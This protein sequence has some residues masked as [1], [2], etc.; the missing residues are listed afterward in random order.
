MGRNFFSFIKNLFK[1]LR[2]KEDKEKISNK[3]N[4]TCTCSVFEFFLDAEHIYIYI[5]YC[6]QIWLQLSWV[7][8]YIIWENSLSSY[9]E[10]F[11][12]ANKFAKR[13][14]QISTCPSA[15]HWMF[16]DCAWS[17]KENVSI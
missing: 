11:T 9:Y 17:E 7:N 13:S 8:F 15:G 3:Q 2:R 10:G 6:L 5:I 14:K 4:D 16:R 1:W 12:A